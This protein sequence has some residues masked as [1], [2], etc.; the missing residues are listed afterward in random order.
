[1]KYFEFSGLVKKYE[2]TFTV[3]STSGGSYDDLGE[4]QPGEAT[5]TAMKG[6]IISLKEDRIYRS[7][8]ML[9]EQDRQ[10]YMTEPLP[11]GLIG[12]IVVYKGNKYKVQ[13]ITDNSEF[14]G[15]YSYLLKFVSAFNG[16]GNSD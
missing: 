16:G 1:M 10:L 13:N 6:A 9:T 12:S 14:T 15:V 5:E 11:E 2:S 8:G 4:W 7:E 3:I